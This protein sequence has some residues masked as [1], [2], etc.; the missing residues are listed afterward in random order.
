MFLVP[1]IQGQSYFIPV[2]GDTVDLK[3]STESG[4]VLLMQ[5]ARG[6][7]TGGGFFKRIDS[8]YAEGT[9]AF[10]CTRMPTYQ[11]LRLGYPNSYFLNATVGT[12]TVTSGIITSLQSTE[13][14][15][16]LT[17]K[18][19]SSTVILKDSDNIKWKLKVNTEGVISVDSTGLN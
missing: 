8:T 17:A 10:D 2:Y 6:T 13:I 19:S 1:F 16:Q 3:N 11:W 18:D 12:A 4:V 7:E 14:N 15:G 5:Y 9:Y